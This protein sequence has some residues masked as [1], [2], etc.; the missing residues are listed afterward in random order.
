MDTFVWNE[1]YLTGESVVD[2]EHQELVRIINWVGRLQSAEAAADEVERVFGYL[3]NYAVT[4]FSHEEELMAQSA[5]DERHV[6]LH[7]RIHQDFA[8][9]I[10]NMRAVDTGQADTEFLL[11]FL[12]NW[13]AYH[14]LGTDQAMARQVQSIRGG[15]SPQQAYETEQ[16]RVSDPATASLLD[17]VHSLYGV[18][19][20]RNQALIDLNRQLEQRV[21]TRTQALSQA[22]CEL[23]LEQAKLKEALATVE[24]T[25]HQLV[26]SER[27]RAGLDAQRVLQQLLTQIVD[28]DPVPTLVINAEHQVTHWN[29]AC[30][31][32]TGRP[33]AEML[34]SNRHWA[35][36]YPNE[37]PIMADLIVS[38]ALDGGFEQL[39]P[40]KF[41]RSPLIDGAFE[42][43]AFFPH[44][45]ESGR[46]LFF[47]AAPLRNATGRIVG[48][49][50]TLQDVTER[51]S[52]E[53]A[54]RAHQAHLEH[55]VEQRTAELREANRQLAEDNARRERAEAELLRRNSELTRLNEQLSTAREQLA[56]SEKLASIGQL[57]AGVAHEINNPIGYVYSNIGALEK[58]IGSLFRIL[59]AYQAVEPDGTTEQGAL[60]GAL[61]QEIDLNFLREDIPL[62]MDESK[63]G[64]T[65]VKKIVQDLKDFSRVDSS[66][67]WQRV[68]LHQGIDSTINI[69]ASEIKYKADVVKHYGDLPE[70]EC[71]PSQLNQVFLNLLVNAA[72]AMG[73][74]HGSITIT[75]GVSGDSV[76][77]EFAD[78]GS[79]IPESIRQKIFDPFFTTKPV[80]KGTGLGLSLSYGI[81][82]NHHGSIELES[83]V[84]KG[85][86]FRI[87]LPIR[88]DADG[89]Q[90]VPNA[91]AASRS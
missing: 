7:K 19:A 55:M 23:V 35:A 13:L 2:A 5:C 58:Y 90:T 71:L 32:V 4:H 24:A 66:Q 30:A 16:A 72:H 28:G 81:V 63:E 88:H 83:E 84:G 49:I 12:T 25:Q 54:L 56:Q 1:R 70:V 17:A 33:A 34:G 3:V 37:R 61:R 26:E 53:E 69:V 22:N 59:Q 52:A 27:K 80:G 77:L 11:R 76:W 6:A 64:I 60:L 87:T 8:Q 86:T 48:A 43:E 73:P 75:T 51:H 45:G 74:E 38:G 78:T 10:S 82:R 65:R 68:N 9:Q 46:W 47:T 62:L 42:A 15:M 39:Y 44:F 50:E 31:A 14:I 36:F 20:G 18:I 41:R 67:S 40:G 85:S 57:A 79:G 21:E 29:K 89:D 91:N